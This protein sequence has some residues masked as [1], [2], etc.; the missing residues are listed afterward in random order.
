MTTIVARQYADRV[1]F[2]ADSQTTLSNGRIMR[3]PKMSKISERNGFIISGAGDVAPCDIAQHI[4][5]PPKPTLSDKKDLYHFMIS[6]V[7]PS[8][9]KCFK[10][11][12][13]K[14]DRP[15]DDSDSGFDLLIAVC[16][17]VFYVPDD[18]SVLMDESGIYVLGSGS[19]NTSGAIKHGATIE[20]AMGYAVDGDA[21]T[22]ASTKSPL[23]RLTQYK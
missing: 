9:K 6:K 4:W 18:C 10:D 11:N 13:Y 17:E 20:E 23:T 19:L 1:E 12:E 7:M 14:L 8:L 5:L 16:G 3:H 2:I 15:A 21:Y 22:L